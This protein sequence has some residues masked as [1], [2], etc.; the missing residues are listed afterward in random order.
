MKKD[1]HAHEAMPFIKFPVSYR[2]SDTQMF[3]P[4][5]THIFIIDDCGVSAALQDPMKY[6]VG[7]KGEFFSIPGAELTITS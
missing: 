6:T 3:I 4:K 5:R 1:I 7:L 2:T